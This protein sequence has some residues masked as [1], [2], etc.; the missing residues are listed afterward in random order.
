MRAILFHNPNAGEKVDKNNILAAMKLA[1]FDAR[2]VSVKDGD[3]DRALEEH[4]D[5]IVVAGG[6]GT[7]TEVLTK[8]SNRS[9]PVA[10]LP[11]GTANNVCRS[12]GI[13]GAPQELVEM[14]KIENTHP[15]DVGM[16][17]KS[18]AES[19]FI[20]G[21]G[22]GVFA[23]FLKSAREREEVEGADNLRMGRAR[24][25]NRIQTAKPIEISIEIDGKPLDG[26]FLGVEVMNVPFT[27]P[28]LPLAKNANVSDRCLD[29]VCFDA[30]R[31][32][33]LQRWLDAPHDEVAPVTERQG[34]TV[35]LRWAGAANRLDDRSQGN[36]KTEQGAEVA[37]ETDQLRVVM[38]VKHPAQKVNE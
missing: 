3:I 15:L 5:L 1:D 21:F 9:V 16:V 28:G 12:L 34:R 38:P 6:D 31:R 29:V 25:R 4:A 26:E 13:A 23:E 11:I 18:G 24:L 35:E 17:R 20:E 8:I 19:R 27:G 14:W 30:S 33:D 36:A 7:I 32:D 22:V 37:C 10:L 2:Y